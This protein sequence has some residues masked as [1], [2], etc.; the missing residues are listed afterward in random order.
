MIVAGTEELQEGDHDE[1]S[2]EETPQSQRSR[3]GWHLPD[4]RE[5]ESRGGR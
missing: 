4:P 2:R 5:S 1:V 3:G